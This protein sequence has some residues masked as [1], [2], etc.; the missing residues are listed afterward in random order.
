[1]FALADLQ[2]VV[3]GRLLPHLLHILEGWGGGEA[4][5]LI[6]SRENKTKQN[7]KQNIV[8]RNALPTTSF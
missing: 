8:S 7:K 2:S 4:S 6:T 3:Q 5:F 1:V